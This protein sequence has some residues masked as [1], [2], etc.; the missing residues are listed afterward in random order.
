MQNRMMTTLTF[1]NVK[2]Y[3][4]QRRVRRCISRAKGERREADPIKPQF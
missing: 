2:A 4:V 1:H 3:P